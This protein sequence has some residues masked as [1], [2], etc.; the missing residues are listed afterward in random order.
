MHSVA[1]ETTTVLKALINKEIR[2]NRNEDVEDRKD[3]V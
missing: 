3:V 1:W 2:I